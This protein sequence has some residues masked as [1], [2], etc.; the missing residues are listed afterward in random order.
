MEYRIKELLKEKGI[1]LLELSE[2]IGVKSPHL[3][4]ALS[5]KGNP[6]IA[7]LEKIADALGVS[8][9]ELFEP[10]IDFTA[11]IDNEGTLYRVNSIDELKQLI[12]TL[13]QVKSK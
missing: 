6:T 11:L 10:A 8:I 5:E 1:T 9:V 7:T 13:E 3:S 12:L 2:K 4:V